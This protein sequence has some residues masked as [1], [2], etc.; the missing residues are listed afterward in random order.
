MKNQDNRQDQSALW[1]A[2]I[3][4]WK[5]SGL[6]QLAFCQREG[7]RYDGFKRWRYRLDGDAVQRRGRGETR[8]ATL[9]PLEVVATNARP[10][11][12]GGSLE[13]RLNGDRRIVVGVDF[14][15]RA[16]H[17]LIGALERLAC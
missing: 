11:T 14:D 3:E 5:A 1:A 2:R 13:V 17:R 4:N 10:R 7:I 8:G 9:V 16:L 15:E 6:T 12:Q